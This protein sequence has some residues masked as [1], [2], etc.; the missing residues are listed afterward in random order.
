MYIHT[1]VH[2]SIHTCVHTY[3]TS[4]LERHEEDEAIQL[5]PQVSLEIMGLKSIVTS[6]VQA[7]IANKLSHVVKAACFFH[8]RLYES[9]LYNVESMPDLVQLEFFC[10]KIKS[11]YLYVFIE[12]ELIQ[13]Y[14][15]ICNSPLKNS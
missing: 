10:Y 3:P 14:L 7:Y 12:S 13:R 11:I 1:E 5:L 2:T 8:T 4:P 15:Q 6:A 9:H